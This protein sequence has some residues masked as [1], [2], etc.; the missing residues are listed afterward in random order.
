LHLLDLIDLF[1]LPLEAYGLALLLECHLDHVDLALHSELLVQCPIHHLVVPTQLLAYIK[2]QLLLLVAH[3]LH[4]PRQLCQ[5]IAL[6]GK[7][8]VLGLM[9][10]SCHYY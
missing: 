8:L 1:D 4:K 7:Q 5:S 10:R 2:H 3:A 6:Q 9:H